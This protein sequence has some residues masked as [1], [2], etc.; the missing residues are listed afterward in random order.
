MQAL[1][2]PGAGT[3]RGDAG[4]RR[5]HPAALPGVQPGDGNLMECFYKAKQNISPQCQKTVADAGYEATIDA[6]RA[7]HAGRAE[8]DRSRQ[9]P[10]RRRTGR[11][12]HFSRQL[13]AD[14]GRRA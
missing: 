6:V 13:A 1:L 10:A 14:G 7:D 9:Q 4:L 5:R 12:G 8:L 2:A 3:S 11:P